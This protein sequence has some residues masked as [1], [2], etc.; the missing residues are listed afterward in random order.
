MEFMIVF[1]YRKKKNQIIGICEYYA[2]YKIILLATEKQKL[3]HI[4][5]L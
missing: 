3:N 1:H 5:P 2:I 4:Y